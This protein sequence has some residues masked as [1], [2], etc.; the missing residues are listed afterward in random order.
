[1]EANV[2]EAY[3]NEGSD[4]P[5]IPGQSPG[6]PKSFSSN[7]QISEPNNTGVTSQVHISNSLD[8]VG[9]LPDEVDKSTMVTWHTR[10]MRQM[11]VFLVFFVVIALVMTGL[12]V[13]RT[14]FFDNFASGINNCN[15]KIC[16]TVRT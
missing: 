8:T 9:Y 16:T 2:N 10:K 3:V 4:V 12:F 7:M 15:E 1:M 11:T 5:G 6:T 14:V 13:W